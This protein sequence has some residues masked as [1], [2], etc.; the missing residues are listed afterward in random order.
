V[1]GFGR[2]LSAEP[3]PPD[4]SSSVPPVDE[5][6]PAVWRPSRE[7]P[8]QENLDFVDEDDASDTIPRVQPTHRERSMTEEP[9]E[10]PTP[11]RTLP[12][13]DALPVGAVVPAAATVPP[14]T[15]VPPPGD[16]GVRPAAGSRRRRGGLIGASVVLVL[17]VG[18]VVGWR[19]QQS[20]VSAQA[21]AHT[22]RPTAELGGVGAHSSARAAASRAT[23]SVS[24]SATA[25]AAV[26]APPATPAPGHPGYDIYTDPRFGF[27]T[28][29]PAG[30]VAQPQNSTGSG[31]EWVGGDEGTVTVRAFGR[32]NPSG[33]TATDEEATY[34]QG[35]QL[36]YSHV[37]GNGLTLSKFADGGSTI[38]YIREVVGPGS[39]D[40]LE[41]TYPASQQD[42]WVHTIA[43]TARN[44]VL[45]DLSR[46]H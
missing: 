41:W 30:F 4:P 2:D 1:P 39:I 19:L 22:G 35:A 32:N 36:R 14:S 44:L 20:P 13:Q 8:A 42:R 3:V 15:A 7:E 38:V 37:D 11:V 25:S 40:T 23:S 46:P 18:G 16:A 5:D 12:A 45:G 27:T 31:L 6:P 43:I 10:P 24:A 26:S 28:I 34:S 29:Y 17:A 33:L 9:A 21:S